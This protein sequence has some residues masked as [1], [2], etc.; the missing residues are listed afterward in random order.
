MFQPSNPLRQAVE[1]GDA[2]KVRGALIGIIQADPGF[3][4]GKLDDA[5]S[6]AESHSVS[7]FEAQNDPQLPMNSEETW[8]S[9]Y[10]ASSVTYLRENFTKE[11]LEHV[12]KVGRKTHPEV[13]RP[14][15]QA[16]PTGFTAREDSRPKKEKGRRMP[17]NRPGP[18]A[19]HKLVLA[20]LALAAIVVVVVLV[21]K[22]AQH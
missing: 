10:F 22:A 18:A 19:L 7:P 15:E 9:A 11:R 4:T 6:Y 12:R 16:I 21:R 2:Y 1:S 13:A 5:I 14:A 3:Q 8:D 20:L 17:S